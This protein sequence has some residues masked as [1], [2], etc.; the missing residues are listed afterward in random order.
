VWPKGG[1]GYVKKAR[2]FLKT[3]TKSSLFDNSM[4]TAVLLNTVVMAMERFDLTDA[5][6]AEM[7]LANLWFTWI[8]IVEASMKIL[9]VGMKK[10]VSE[11]MNVLDL[12]V[13][14]LSIVELAMAGGG[15]SLSAF[16]TVRIFRTFRVL[17]VI[18]LLRALESMKLII[19]VL[20]RSIGSFMYIAMLLGICCF[21]FALLG[22]TL[23]GGQFNF[24][25]GK[26]RGN[27]D[28]FNIAFTTVFQVLTM[29]NWQTVLFDSM[30]NPNLG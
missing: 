12:S 1:Y 11:V 17:R 18:R 10:Y 26:P 9:G 2:V 14:L 23:F 27:F 6:E 13:V 29:E 22:K 5:E 19:N 24:P 28:G 7:E 3:I 20:T 8:F 21:I 25:E 30:R 4:L 16:R 15:G